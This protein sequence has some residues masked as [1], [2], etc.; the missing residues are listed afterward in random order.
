[1]TQV[2]EKDLEQ[3]KYFREAEVEKIYGINRNTLRR[4]RW[5]GYGI[6]AKIV[7]REKGKNR[8]GI[9]LYALEDI[10]KAIR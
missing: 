6:P 5:G 2:K 7:G 9:V 4:Q 10:E 8:G 1:M 3:R